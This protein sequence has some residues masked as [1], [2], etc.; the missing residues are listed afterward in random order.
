MLK[1]YAPLLGEDYNMLLESSPESKKKVRMLGSLLFIPV[2]TWMLVLFIFSHD[3]F[4]LDTLSSFVVGAIGALVILCIERSIIMSKGN[5]A[6]TLFRI[7]IGLVMALLSSVMVDEILFKKDL[8]NQKLVDLEQNHKE[9]NP[10]EGLIRAEIISFNQAYLNKKEQAAKEAQG[11]GSGL[12]GVG[13]I[14]NLLTQQAD[15]LLQQKEQKEQLLASVQL[16]KNKLYEER[17][18]EIMSGKADAELLKNIEALISFLG[19]SNFALCIFI[20]FFIFMTLLEFMVI[21]F[22]INSKETSYER[23]LMLMET[24]QKSKMEKIENRILNSYN[25]MKASKEY[26]QSENVLK[27]NMHGIF[28]HK[29]SNN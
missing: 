25:P 4:K 9:Q 10:E 24:I 22:K 20:L 29:N 7:M 11:Q 3:F 15:E 16:Q 12:R 14:T 18:N 27:D 17:R 28:H 5:K 1:F 8:Q 21:M 13:K 23:R 19:T 2:I 6:I 26:G